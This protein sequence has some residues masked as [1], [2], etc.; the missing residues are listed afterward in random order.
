MKVEVTVT[1]EI[2]LDVETVARWFCG[3][4]DEDQAQLFIDINRVAYEVMQENSETQWYYMCKHLS[5]CKCSNADTRDML[6]Y[7]AKNLKEPT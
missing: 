6:R 3:L 7:W 2:D 4:S 1:H 5:T